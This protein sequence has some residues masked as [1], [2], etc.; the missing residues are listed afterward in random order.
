MIRMP[1]I[2]IIGLGILLIIP[3][4]IALGSGRDP[5]D[6]K[7]DPASSYPH[8]AVKRQEFGNGARSYWLFEPADPTPE[9]APVIVF[10]HGWLAVNPGAYGAWIDHLVR[11]GNVVIYPRYQLDVATLPTEFLPNALWAIRDGLDVLSTSPKHVQPDL[12]RFALMGHSAGGNLSAQIAAVASEYQIPA[13]KAV[14]A[15][16][17]GEVQPMNEPKLSLIPASTLL[18][19]TAGEDDR[20]VGDGRARQIFSETTSIPKERKKFILYRSDLHGYPMLIADHLAP[21]GAFR[22]FDSG[23]GLFRNLQMNRAQVNAIDRAGFWR[24]A[25][26]TLEAAF[27]GMTLDQATDRG[28]ILKHLGYWSDGRVVERPVVG[29]DLAQIPRVFPTNGIRLIKWT[30]KDDF[31]SGLKLKR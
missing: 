28:E 22:G 19:V 1:R 9:S 10:N 14:L 2:G 17:P 3:Q 6:P 24:L 30:M 18:V 20:V 27:R 12:R 23:D 15:L 25:D 26:I 13:A 16:M 8:Q 11:R 21:T 4:A 7:D 31:G 5:D 29:D